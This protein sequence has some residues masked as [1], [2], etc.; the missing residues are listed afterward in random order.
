MLKSGNYHLKWIEWY[1]NRG[2]VRSGAFWVK[3]WGGSDSFTDEDFYWENRIICCNRFNLW[4]MFKQNY[5][6]GKK[7]LES[8]D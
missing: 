3:R 7:G 1:W 8:R 2:L 5:I 4:L 6:L